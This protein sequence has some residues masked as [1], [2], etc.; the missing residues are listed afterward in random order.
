MHTSK[1]AHPTRFIKANLAALSLLIVILLIRVA[2]AN[3][4]SN[5][6]YAQSYFMRTYQELQSETQRLSNQVAELQSSQRLA[7]E[8]GRLGL[9]PARKIYYIQP[10][11][12]FV[13]NK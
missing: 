2:I 1:Q 3:H 8:S 10:T 9:V 6:R 11:A 5:Q 7:A 12:A 13:Y 4:A